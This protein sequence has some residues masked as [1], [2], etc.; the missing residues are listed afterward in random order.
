MRSRLTALAAMALALAASA[1]AL[2]QE[3]GGEAAGVPAAA[4]VATPAEEPEPAAPEVAQAE[5][6]SAPA[7]PERSLEHQIAPWVLIG[8]GGVAI[9]GS[10]ALYVAHVSMVDDMLAATAARPVSITLAEYS[11]RREQAQVTWLG[12]IGA[13]VAGAALVTTGVVLELTWE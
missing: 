2:A 8:L 11:A 12:S 10:A 4:P 13:L 5:A 7:G 3:T 9:V 6:E 1:P